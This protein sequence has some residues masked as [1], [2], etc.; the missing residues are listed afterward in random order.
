MCAAHAK[1]GKRRG[2]RRR[3]NR[4]TAAPT[5][6][7]PAGLSAARGRQLRYRTAYLLIILLRLYI[8]VLVSFAIDSLF[9]DGRQADT[10]NHSVAT[11]DG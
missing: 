6:E 9:A 10:P 5:P 3:T 7:P 1:S 11:I 8:V 2:H 4:R